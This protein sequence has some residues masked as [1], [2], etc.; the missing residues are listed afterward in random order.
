MIRTLAG[1]F[2][3][4]IPAVFIIS[5]MRIYSFGLIVIGNCETGVPFKIFE[6]VRACSLACVSIEVKYPPRYLSEI[7]GL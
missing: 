6:A 2:F 4:E 5:Q 7:S 3:K 1:I